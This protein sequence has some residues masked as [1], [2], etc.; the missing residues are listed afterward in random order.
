MA[1]WWEA[2]IF[3][4]GT[5]FGIPPVERSQNLPSVPGLQF[6][7]QLNVQ[8]SLSETPYSERL[9]GIWTLRSIAG[10]QC[11]FRH[12]TVLMHGPSVFIYLAS[13]E[14]Y[15]IAAYPADVNRFLSGCHGHPPSAKH[16]IAQ[17]T[18]AQKRRGGG[19]CKRLTQYNLPYVRY[20]T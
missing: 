13:F 5:I 19:M 20:G 14:Q 1:A 7:C 8:D 9:S 12:V 6:P 15:P 10:L 11:Q 2:S 3:V 16:L 4:C 17:E 18:D